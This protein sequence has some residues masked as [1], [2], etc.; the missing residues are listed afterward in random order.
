MGELA[1]ELQITG[2]L[3][4][5]GAE[6]AD[7]E[8]LGC[9]GVWT[10][11]SMNDPMLPACLALASTQR[12][13]VGTGVVI[14]LARSPMTIAQEAHDLQA[15]SDGRFILGLGSQIKPAITRRYSMPWSK[16]VAQMREMAGAVRAIFD[17]WYDGKRLDFRG[18][19]Y[20]LTFNAEPFRPKTEVPRPAPI[21]LAGVGP[22][23][24]AMA[25]EMGDG[26]ITHRFVTESFLREVT[27]PAL[28]KGMDRRAHAPERFE[29]VVTIHVAVGEDPESLRA[30]RDEARH[31]IAFYGTTPS[32]RPVLDHH[33][34]GHIHEKLNHLSHEGRWA[35]LDQVIDDDILDLFVPS[36][37]AK[38][39]AAEIERRYSDFAHHIWLAKGQEAVVPHLL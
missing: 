17:H 21:F 6:A 16:P 31:L 32:Y 37:T 8:R 35:E 39:V 7:A 3:K 19:F 20:N 2:D 1:V 11:E 4:H 13:M 14:A 18:E 12:L 33:G 23:M 36:G 25:G 38:E 26:Y 29:I 9:T 27:L 5:A 22:L 15:F 34:L 10:T 24:T 30:A 28:A